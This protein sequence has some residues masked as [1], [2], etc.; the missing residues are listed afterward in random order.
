MM[1]VMEI[2]AGKHNLIGGRI[3]GSRKE[4]EEQKLKKGETIQDEQFPT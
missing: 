2:K 3:K 1:M 4:E